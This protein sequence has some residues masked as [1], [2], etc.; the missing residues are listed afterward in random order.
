[1]ISLTQKRNVNNK[2]KKQIE[3]KR[4]N[5][6]EN[7]CNIRNIQFLASSSAVRPICI[8]FVDSRCIYNTTLLGDF[9]F[10]TTDS[11]N[12]CFICLEGGKQKN[13]KFFFLITC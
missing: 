8:W 3:M 13:F 12:L 5:K 7:Y 11:C 4:K 2:E 1:L 10:S 6:I 9:G